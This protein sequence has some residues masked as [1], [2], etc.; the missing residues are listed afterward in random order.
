MIE[1]TDTTR[2]HVRTGIIAATFAFAIAIGLLVLH[3]SYTAIAN[4]A[5]E[6]EANRWADSSR[7]HAR[8]ADSL[9][10]GW[11]STNAELAK[12]R[13]QYAPVVA[14]VRQFAQSLVVD[15]SSR[16]H[17][18]EIRLTDA[19]N[20]SAR[21]PLDTVSMAT[22]LRAASI[23]CRTSCRGS[24]SIG[25]RRRHISRSSKTVSQAITGA[26]CARPASSSPHGGT[27]TTPIAWRYARCVAQFGLVPAEVR[28]RDRRC[29]HGWRCLSREQGSGAGHWQARTHALARV[30]AAHRLADHHPCDPQRH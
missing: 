28:H 17:V 10:R 13:V 5:S 25:G 23:R 6:R 18:A 19:A 27:R 24:S 26:S 8:E 1:L 14:K 11:D 22:I 3:D 30:L 9:Q 29:R 7:A 12:T 15:T 21:E 2:A 20:L 16:N 4:Q